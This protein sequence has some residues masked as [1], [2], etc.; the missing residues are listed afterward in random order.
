MEADISTWRKTGHFYFALTE[1]WKD[2]RPSVLKGV[3]FF[4]VDM[5]GTEHH[6]NSERIVAVDY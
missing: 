6:I 5:L 1:F 4:N 2:C 3:N